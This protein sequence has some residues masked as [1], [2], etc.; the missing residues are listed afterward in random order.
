MYNIHLMWWYNY[1]TKCIKNVTPLGKY[2]LFSYRL[3]GCNFL[4]GMMLVQGFLSDCLL[5]YP[6]NSHFLGFFQ[7]FIFKN[8]TKSIIEFLI[9]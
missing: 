4:L 5:S 7:L 3:K 1:T 8:L 9:Q 6:Y 2:R